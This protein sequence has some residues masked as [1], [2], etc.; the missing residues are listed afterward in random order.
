MREEAK[1]CSRHSSTILRHKNTTIPCRVAVLSCAS[2]STRE[3]RA[4]LTSPSQTKI[5]TGMT[6]AP[7]YCNACKKNPSVLL[8]PRLQLSS[9]P[10]RCVRVV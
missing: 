7:H 9:L 8:P 2:N 6:M 4:K 5:A 10:R 3:D 1:R